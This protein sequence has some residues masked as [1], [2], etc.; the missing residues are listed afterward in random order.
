MSFYLD[1]KWIQSLNDR[2]FPGIY[3]AQV[4]RTPY[5]TGG[6]QSQ[7]L[8]SRLRGKIY[9]VSRHT[10]PSRFTSL[11]LRVAKNVSDEVEWFREGHILMILV[12]L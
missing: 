10:L 6:K 8:C 4:R 3:M 11:L 1:R 12:F 9:R 7:K 5:F 2:S